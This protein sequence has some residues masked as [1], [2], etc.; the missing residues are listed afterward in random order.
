MKHHKLFFTIP[1]GFILTLVMLTQTSAQTGSYD[2]YIVSV[3]SGNTERVTF[4]DDADEYNPSFS[5][6]GKKVAHDVVGGTA[7]LGHSIY[8]TDVNSGVSTLLAGGEGGNDASWSPNG[9]YIAFDR[10]P[11]GDPNI[12]TVPANGGTPTL[13]RENAVDPEWSNNSKRLVFTDITDGSV[14]TVNLNGGSETVVATFGINASWSANGKY[15]AYTDGDNIFKISVRQSG[16]PKGIPVQ[17]TNDGAGV[18]NQQPSWSNNSKTIVFHSNRVSGDFDLWTVSASGGTPSLLAGLAD[19]GDFDPSYSKN[20][21]YVAYSGFT[22]PVP[23]ASKKN[24]TTASASENS[25]PTHFSLNQNFPN[26][27]N[28]STLIQYTIPNAS[29]VK[30]EIFN[31]T[32]ESVATLV[33]GF[34]S[35]GYYEVSFNAGDLPSGMYLYRISAGTFVQTRKMILMK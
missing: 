1:L 26:P 30:I 5:N 28:P 10:I 34:K 29:N 12:Y 20:G 31:I 33:D 23:S 2:I 11:V 6:N 35:E 22:I 3:K 24:G 14:R 15:I 21:K 27:F 18:F 19:Y 17:L 8:I 13:V 7:P 4:I 32:G 9:Q 25:V 16:E